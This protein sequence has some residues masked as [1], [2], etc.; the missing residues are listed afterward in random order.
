MI[1]HVYSENRWQ[2]EHNNAT[3]MH[4]ILNDPNR[5]HALKERPCCRLWLRVWI[6]LLW[7]YPH[8]VNPIMPWVCCVCL[9]LEPAFL[10]RWPVTDCVT[11]SSGGTTWVLQAATFKTCALQPLVSNTLGDVCTGSHSMCDCS[12][13]DVRKSYFIHL[14]IQP[15]PNT[16]ALKFPVS[17]IILTK[18]ELN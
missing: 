8:F 11:D 5:K 15:K 10:T 12:F 6:F 3:T 7:W 16:R 18:S 9:Q 13:E 1:L 14:I 4:S 17:D 2:T